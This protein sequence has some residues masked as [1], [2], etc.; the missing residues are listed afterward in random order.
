VLGIVVLQCEVS[1]NSGQAQAVAEAL[2]TLRGSSSKALVI[3]DA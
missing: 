2:Y 3:R 1:G